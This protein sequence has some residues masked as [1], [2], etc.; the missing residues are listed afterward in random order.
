MLTDLVVLGIVI[1]AGLVLASHRVTTSRAW[2]ATVTPLAS[3]IGSGFLVIGPILQTAYG[4]WS[5][6]VMIGL[7]AVAYLFG[8]AV[9][10][11][12]ATLDADDRRGSIVRGLETAGGWALA[13]AYVISVAYYLNLFGAFG[14]SLTAAD[15]PVSA[16]L[17]TSAVLV[18]ILLVGWTRG[19]GALEQLEQVFVSVKLAII[20][21]LIA[22][23]VVFN[24][25]RAGDDALSFTAPGLSGW[26]ALT[27]AFGLVVTIQGFETSRYLGDRYDARTRILTMRRAQG[28]ATLIY[29]V[30]IGLLAFAFTPE[31]LPF[32][33]TAI[34]NLMEIVSPI[35][36]LLLVA[37]ALSAQFSAAVADTGGSGGLFVELSGRRISLR[38]AYAGLVGVGL[39]LTWTTDLFNIIAYASRA[40]AA[41]YA[42]QAAIAAVGRWQAGSRGLAGLFALLAMLGAAMALFG[43][44]AEG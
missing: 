31:E 14:V 32:G 36:P 42:I 23:L 38:Q 10:T 22:G 7:C 2:R 33:E 5:P 19:F 39:V 27:L 35:L 43:A 25:E 37:A 12:I 28:I 8:A 18:L 41:Y 44:P 6:L 26:S 30:Y 29:V 11:N 34:V 16:R 15:D 1:L 21:G 20:L 4:S 9:R 24:G 13:G 40:F 3:I 17:L